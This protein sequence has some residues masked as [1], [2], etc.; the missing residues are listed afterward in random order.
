MATIEALPAISI[1]PVKNGWMVRLPLDEGDVADKYLEKFPGMYSQLCQKI[2]E[3]SDP[4]M[5]NIR[6]EN[7]EPETYGESGKEPVI[8]IKKAGD[9]Y[10][11][12]TFPEVL[13]FLDLVVQDN[14]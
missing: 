8:K 10:I 3:E 4:V 13:D 5:A 12:S 1:I 7:K 14:P 11:F 2:D 6:R 9:C